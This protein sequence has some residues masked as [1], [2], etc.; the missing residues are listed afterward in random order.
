MNQRLY[1]GLGV[2]FVAIPVG[3]VTL[4]GSIPTDDLVLSTG[5][6]VV[7]LAGVLAILGGLGVSVGGVEWFQ[8]VGLSDVLFGGWV[9]GFAVHTVVQQ[10]GDVGTLLSVGLVGVGSLALTLIGLDWVRGPRY[11]DVESYENAPLFGRTN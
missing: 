2:L 10:P 3:L 8:F 6:V 11:F 7:P 1:I 9:T 5:T 4:A